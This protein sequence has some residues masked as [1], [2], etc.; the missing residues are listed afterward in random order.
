MYLETA[1]G[2]FLFGY[3]IFRRYFLSSIAFTTSIGEFDKT[4][5]IIYSLIVQLRTDGTKNV[6]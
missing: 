2:S 4:L 1:F 3:L 6:L 5:F